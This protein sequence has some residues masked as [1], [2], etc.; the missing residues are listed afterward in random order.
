MSDRIGS[1]KVARLPKI[2]SLKRKSTPRQSAAHEHKF[3]STE[4]PL[5]PSLVVTKKAE[6][7]T[8][9]AKQ[10]L[11]WRDV[12]LARWGKNLPVFA[13]GGGQV[14]FVKRE[15]EAINRQ[16]ALAIISDLQYNHRLSRHDIKT[17]TGKS[18]VHWNF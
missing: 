17:L 13:I 1:P 2:G 7:F 10:F 4:D 11:E 14:N 18:Q 16:V 15:R 8:A 6:M 12:L 9:V 3:L 5:S